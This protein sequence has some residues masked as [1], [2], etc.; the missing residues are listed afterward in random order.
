LNELESAMPYVR[1]KKV[2]TTD[3]LGDPIYEDV[4]PT[5]RYLSLTEKHMSALRNR[6]KH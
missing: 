1:G 6:N 2:V 4:G 3:E 5:P